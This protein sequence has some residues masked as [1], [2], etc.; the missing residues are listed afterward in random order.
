MIPGFIYKIHCNETEEDYYGSTVNFS[1]RMSC[2]KCSSETQLKKRNC[3]SRKIIERNNYSAEVIEVFLFD[4]KKELKKRE[5]Y[6]LDNFPC[7]NKYPAY[8]TEEELKERKRIYGLTEKSLEAK[9][10]YR[11]SHREEAIKRSAEHYNKNKEEI[12]KKRKEKITCIC[13]MEYSYNHKA[14][15][16]KTKRHINKMAEQP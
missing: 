2:H 13:G 8:K 11:E 6:Y 12:N 15:H 7:I 1:N 10:K 4:D 16:Y 5:Q 14:R 3:E 9:K